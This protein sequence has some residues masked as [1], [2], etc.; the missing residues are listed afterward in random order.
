[1]CN[2]ANMHRHH[3]YYVFICICTFVKD[4]RFNSTCLCL[5]NVHFNCNFAWTRENTGTMWKIIKWCKHL[6]IIVT[7]IVANVLW[8]YNHSTLPNELLHTSLKLK[9]NNNWTIVATFVHITQM[10]HY[11]FLFFVFLSVQSELKPIMVLLVI[12]IMLD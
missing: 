9:L 7:I 8:E 3:V 1:M 2:F 11:S 6:C 12:V 4:H 5:D 10:N